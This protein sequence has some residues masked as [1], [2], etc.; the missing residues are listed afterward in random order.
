MIIFV[1]LYSKNSN[2]PM[3]QLPLNLHT[4]VNENEPPISINLDG[5]FFESMRL[6]AAGN[7]FVATSLPCGDF[8][9]CF[10][11][12]L[13]YTGYQAFYNTNRMYQCSDKL[14]CRCCDCNW[15]TIIQIFM[16][17]FYI[18]YPI[19]PPAVKITYSN[20]VYY[21]DHSNLLMVHSNEITSDK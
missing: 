21:Y 4:R 2:S 17:S 7:H 1:L 6:R 12:Y 3:V 16:P 13:A 18:H 15:S 19:N 20:Y 5:P 9:R 14:S 11:C 8:K 10:H